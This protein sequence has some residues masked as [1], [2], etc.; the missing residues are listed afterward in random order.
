MEVGMTTQTYNVQETRENLPQLLEKVA[1][2][3]EVIIA[4]GGKPLA[5][6]SRVDDTVGIRFGVL[7]GKVR[8]SE[9]FDAPLPEGMLSEFEGK[10]SRC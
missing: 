2:G 9:D 1:S 7:K 10:G 4:E 3:A 5:C 8:I 6:I